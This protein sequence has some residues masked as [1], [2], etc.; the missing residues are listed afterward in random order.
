MKPR[1][2]SLLASGTEIVCGIGAGDCLVGRSHE[3][4]N[5]EWVRRLPA[6][7]RPTFDP[8]LSS[9]AIDALVKQRLR[10]GEPLYDVDTGLIESLGPDLLI[11]QTHCE[12]CAVTPADVERA[13]GGGVAGQVL[14]LSAG[15][16][17]GIYEGITRVA[18]ALER[19]AA[20][21][22][23]ISRMQRRIDA[24]HNAVKDCPP[25]RVAMLEWVAPLYAMGN[26]APELL[27]SANGRPALGT[28]GYSSVVTWQDVLASDPDFLVVAPCGFDLERTRRE[29]PTLSSFPG[30]RDLRVVREGRVILAD[31]NRYFNRSGTTV[32]E[33][34]EILA[35]A[36]HGY[37]SSLENAWEFYKA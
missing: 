9:A 4:D 22:E 7:T 11:T 37:P 5:P 17:P 19:P 15:T 6:C 12:V 21:G 1:V 8:S 10:S 29:L 2:I 18:S 20:G 35:A 13:G 31:G 25:P 16:L 14:G 32:V 34:V 36:L 23:L 24:L 3:C 33:T 27:Q 28:E 26:W 30:W